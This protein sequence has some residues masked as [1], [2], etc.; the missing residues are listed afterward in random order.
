M[1]AATADAHDTAVFGVAASIAFGMLML[2]NAV[3]T[4]LL[5]R[6][7]AEDDLHALVACARRALAWSFVVAV[8]LSASAAA[9][10]PIGLPLVL[11]SAYADAGAP[12][13]VLCFGIPLITSSGVIGIALLSVGRLRPLGTQVAA[14]LAVNLIVLALLVPSLGAVGAALA[15]VS[16]EL[17]GFLLLAH[18]ACRA[19][20]GLLA[21][22]VHALRR[23]GRASSAATT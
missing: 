15:T 6:L 13:M 4:A 2:P 18:F 12:F 17:V 16:C 14:S 5:P 3:T 21:L 11:G 23:R 20:P 7:A 8:L 10:V 22:D 9:V 1:L 19:L